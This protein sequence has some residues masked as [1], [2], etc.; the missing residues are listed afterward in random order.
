MTREDEL[1]R[2]LNSGDS[3]ALDGLIRL[4]YPEIFRY[5]Q[6]HTS[7]YQTAEDAAQETFLK[8]VR[9]MDGY[10]HR[11]RFRAYLYK[12]AANICADFWRQSAKP[13]E[14]TSE[15][16]VET[17]FEKVE[18]ELSLK[19]MLDVLPEKQRE[20]VILRYVH[21]L[22]LREIA[23]VLNEPLR[24]VQSRLRSAIRFLEENLKEGG[25]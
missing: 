15:V 25:R 8:A 3:S 24:T 10:T 20:A 2:K 16:C 12:I 4:Y 13:E 23:S 14:V 9:H 11:G 1:F 6:R 17:G 22:K 21:D 19:A 5:C 7:D 18:A